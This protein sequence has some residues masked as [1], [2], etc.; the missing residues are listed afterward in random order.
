M[1]IL[2]RRGIA[3]KTM[4]EHHEQGAGHG[5]H[6]ALGYSQSPEPTIRLAIEERAGDPGSETRKLKRGVGSF[7]SF[8]DD[9]ARA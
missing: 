1:R 4:R 5:A 6:A 9:V 7:L 2:Y 3:L 8:A